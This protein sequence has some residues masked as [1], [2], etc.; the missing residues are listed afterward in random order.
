MN[1]PSSEV[2]AIIKE[3]VDMQRDKYGPN[4]KEILSKE[5]AEDFC[6]RYGPTLNALCRRVKP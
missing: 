3:W 2:K 6:N 1:Q 5:M 4:W